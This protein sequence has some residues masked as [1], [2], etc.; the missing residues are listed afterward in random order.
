MTTNHEGRRL[1]LAH[2]WV[3]VLAFGMAAAMAMMQAISRANLEVPYRSARMYYM[4]VTAHGVLMALVFTTF[5]IMA[6]GYVIA[7]RENGAIKWPKLAW[8]CYFLSLAGVVM[9]LAT[10][11]TFKSS[12]LYT[13]YPPLQAHPLFYIGLTLL[14]V[15]SWGWVAS[16]I[17]SWRQARAANPDRPVSLAI[18][19]TV[20]NAMLWALAT[21]GVAAEMLF[22]LIPWS[23]GLVQDRRSAAGTHS[24]LVLRPSAGVFLDSPGLHHL[25]YRA[26]PRGRWEAVLRTAGTNGVLPVPDAFHPGRPSPPVPGPGDSCRLEAAAHLQHDDHLVPQ[27]RDGLHH[28]GLAGSRGTA[29]RRQ[30][31]LRLDSHAAL[32]QSDGGERAPGR[33]CCSWWAV[34]AGRSTPPTCSTRWST[35]PPGSRPTSISPWAARRLSRSWEPATGWCP[36]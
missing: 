24:V 33:A 11:F 25:V 23:L 9:A 15:G 21:I 17:A 7:R 12:V 8:T 16:M 5:F 36:R 2:I 14:V 20:A 31:T 3:A 10:V 30:G 22:Q 28:R 13:F 29:A 26:S 35:T 32:G 6:L 18:H 19:A 34:S 27:L 1:I 4:S